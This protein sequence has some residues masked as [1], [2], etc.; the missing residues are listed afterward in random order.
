MSLRRTTNRPLGARQPPES[1][2]DITRYKSLS[3]K[4]QKAKK[5]PVVE[6]N[7]YH[8]ENIHPQTI[9]KTLQS[10]ECD[11]KITQPAQSELPT[12]DLGVS[13]SRTTSIHHSSLAPSLYSKSSI[14]SPSKVPNRYELFIDQQVPVPSLK[15]HEEQKDQ[16]TL[17]KK[18]SKDRCQE[19]RHHNDEDL[20]FRSNEDGGLKRHMSVHSN[21]SDI[22]S[23]FSMETAVTQATTLT[24][25]SSFDN[26]TNGQSHSSMSE[27]KTRI[28]SLSSNSSSLYTHEN[29]IEEEKVIEEDLEEDTGSSKDKN[30]IENLHLEFINAI[31]LERQPKKPIDNDPPFHIHADAGVDLN[32]PV[33]ASLESKN[34]SQ[35]TFSA[36]HKVTTDNTPTE[37]RPLSDDDFT[38]PENDNSMSPCVT[39]STTASQKKCNDNICNSPENN[40][41]FT[42]IAPNNQ[43]IRPCKPTSIWGVPTALQTGAPGALSHDFDPSLNQVE[44]FLTTGASI[45]DDLSE[46]NHQHFKVSSTILCIILT[47]D[48]IYPIVFTYLLCLYM[49]L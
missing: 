9:E 18:I 27:K 30:S 47:H 46:G 42:V 3:A 39:K 11:K 49:I 14:H 40:T 17:L 10:S 23:N 31:S 37:R 32:Q 15:M 33:N 25:I 29:D 45:I 19:Q 4:S 36:S 16:H 21:D 22:Y 7:E 24:N 44:R 13:K 5:D 43:R 1:F 2:K 41:P 6:P 48:Q 35:P 34:S 28:T 26:S 38:N 20:S 12:T 8:K